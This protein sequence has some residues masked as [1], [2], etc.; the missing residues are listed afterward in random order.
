MLW[1]AL[2]LTSELE[3]LDVGGAANPYSELLIEKKSLTPA[4]LSYFRLR[5]RQDGCF[6]PF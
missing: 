3:T 4:P 2:S 5:P 1:E 6:N